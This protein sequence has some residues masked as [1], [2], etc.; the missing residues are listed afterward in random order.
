MAGRVAATLACVLPA[1]MA[2]VGQDNIP[3]PAETI[4]SPEP[5]EVAAGEVFDGAGARYDRASYTCQGQNEGGSSTNHS[6]FRL[7]CPKF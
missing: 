2:C 7:S 4:S 3:S 6:L 5:I 1:A